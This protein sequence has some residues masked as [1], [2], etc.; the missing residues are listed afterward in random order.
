MTTPGS[1][2]EPLDVREL[3]RGDPT[4]E[5]VLDALEALAE[6]NY[7][8]LAEA[9][10][11]QQLVPEGAHQ[12]RR[13]NEMMLGRVGV[14]FVAHRGEALV[15]FTEGSIRF[16]PE[17]VGRQKVGLLANHFVVPAE[18]RTGTGRALHDALLAWFEERS[19]A[20][21]ELQV[22]Q[23]NPGARAFWESLGYEAELTQLRRDL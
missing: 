10:L 6:A 5:A 22:L 1:A 11:R 21:V 12:W 18:R 9:G 20:S 4:N 16:T 23:G 19:C 17:H 8:A 3:R 15:G 13:M 14:L 7:A 2:P